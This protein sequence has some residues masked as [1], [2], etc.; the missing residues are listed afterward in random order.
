MNIQY[1]TTIYAIIFASVL[2]GH[3]YDFNAENE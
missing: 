3:A 1:I 2:T